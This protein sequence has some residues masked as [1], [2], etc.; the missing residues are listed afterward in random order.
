MEEEE[1]E[2]IPLS[3]TSSTVTLTQQNVHEQV[4]PQCHI[5]TQ[6]ASGDSMES[7]SESVSQKASP[8]YSLLSKS[9][10]SSS[11]Q[12][13]YDPPNKGQFLS[14]N[15]RSDQTKSMESLRAS[16]RS[17]L[18]SSE[19]DMRRMYSETSE[20]KS[21]ESIEREVKLKRHAVSGE[22]SLLMSSDES[23]SMAERRRV[24]WSGKMRI[25]QHLSLPPPAGYLSLSPGERR[26]TILSPHSPHKVP[27]M[28][29]FG[30]ATLKSRRKKATVLPKLVLP[31]SDSDMSEVCLQYVL[32][33][34]RN[35]R[36]FQYV[37]EPL[38]PHELQ[39]LA[40]NINLDDLDIEGYG[41]DD[42]QED[43]DILHQNES[44]FPNPDEE[45]DLLDDG[46]T[47][48]PDSD[49]EPLAHIG[50]DDDGKYQ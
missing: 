6:Q 38:N 48:P 25:P 10:H 16:P 42:E 12:E 32:P 1:E 31:R 30:T 44:L 13:D 11:S 23:I 50:P 34:S 17:F 5:I 45:L 9:P 7:E 41:F 37:L 43:E 36:A 24:L 8:R 40:D 39:E 27:E 14:A 28:L 29:H 20:A 47:N 4:T 19:R 49:D 21:L 35:P 3:K 22:G 2:P 15:V 18:T 46:I 33:A 26:L